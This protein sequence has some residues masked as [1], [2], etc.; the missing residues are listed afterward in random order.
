MEKNKDSVS[1]PISIYPFL[2]LFDLYNCDATAFSCSSIS[3][4]G[5][6]PRNTLPEKLV[7]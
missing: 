3:I 4:P 2:C 5:R 1:F 7:D 6:D